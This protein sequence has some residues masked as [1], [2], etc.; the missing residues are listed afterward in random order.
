[1][2]YP[3]RKVVDETVKLISGEIDGTHTGSSFFVELEDLR[4]PLY[5]NKYQYILYQP[6]FKDQFENEEEDLA[7]DQKSKD[8]FAV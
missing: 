6:M 2:F 1:M 7:D 5:Y 3:G 4:V 8:E